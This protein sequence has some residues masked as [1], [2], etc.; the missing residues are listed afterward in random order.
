[1]ALLL[2]SARIYKPAVESIPQAHG[3]AMNP[4]GNPWVYPFV[5]TLAL[6]GGRFSEV[7]GLLV[8]DVSFKLNK[9]YIRP[10]DLRRLKTRGSKR[11]V[12]LWPQLREILEEYFA[13][14]ERTGG[15]GAL[16]FPGRSKGEGEVMVRDIRKALDVIAKRAGFESGSVR[17]HVLR[18]SY[19]A[20]RIQTSDRGRPVAMYTVARELGHSSLDMVSDRYGHLHDR[21]EDGGTEE[22]SFRVETYQEQLCDRLE[23]L[24]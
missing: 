16:L 5:A 15:I 1:M 19:C 17:P 18:H 3:G 24:V 14:R 13:E 10:N 9:V 6:T 7:A 4:R 22:V 2:E 11:S 8:D 12:P 21:A 20:A 23:A